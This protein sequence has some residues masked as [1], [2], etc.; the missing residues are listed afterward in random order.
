MNAY[1]QKH[2]ISFIDDYSRYLYL[3]MLHNKHEAI[4]AF[5]VFKPEEE[6]QCGKKMKIV[7][8][9]KGGEFY[10]RYTKDRQVPGLFVKFLQVHGIVAQYNMLG[11]PDQ[12][13]VAKRRNRMLLDMV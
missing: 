10:G 7:K 11:S 6:K 1:D 4:D 3:C 2:F 9:D 12:N 5:K 13:G 8:S